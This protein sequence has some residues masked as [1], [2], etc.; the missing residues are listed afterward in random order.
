MDAAVATQSEPV[1]LEPL[2]RAIGAARLPLSFEKATQAALETALTDA[3]YQYRREVPLGGGDVV[4]FLVGP[5]AIELKVKGHAKQIY[6][7]LLRY[8]SHPEVE[9]LVLL[10]ARA[11]HL[12]ATLEG[13]PARIVSLG[14]AWL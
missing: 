4:D 6:R 12:P 7:Q 14:K 5:I 13:K 11:M 8:A 1:E 3:G 9:A 2:C 10:T